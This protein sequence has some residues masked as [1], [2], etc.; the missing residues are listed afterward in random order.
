MFTTRTIESFETEELVDRARN[1][2]GFLSQVDAADI[3]QKS[4]I[5]NEMAF[6]AV[7]AACIL[8]KE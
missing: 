2:L 3:L 4:G 7:K 1:L 5:S 6:L 8:L